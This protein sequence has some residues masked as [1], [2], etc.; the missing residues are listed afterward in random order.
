MERWS[1]VSLVLVA[2]VLLAGCNEQR[3]NYEALA[4]PAGAVSSMEG[5]A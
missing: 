1:V 2:S 3:I 4:A 5:A